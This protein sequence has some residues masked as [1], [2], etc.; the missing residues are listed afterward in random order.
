MEIKI[1]NYV[2]E[3]DR[4]TGYNAYFEYEIPEF[5][6][7]GKRNKGAGEAN[8]RLISYNTTM[9]RAVKN[10]IHDK[11]SNEEVQISLEEFI[12]RYKAESERING[13]L[14]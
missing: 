9:E 8:R 6:G 2:I 12:E 4:D 3:L 14:K 10:I 5:D 1:D 11:L 7:T 13:M